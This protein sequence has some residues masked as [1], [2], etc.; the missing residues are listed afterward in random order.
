M[1]SF[2]ESQR[3]FWNKFGDKFFLWGLLKGKVYINK[4]CKIYNPK[5]NI[6]QETAAI[7]VD[8]LQHIV[9]NLEHCIQLCVGVGGDHF[10]HPI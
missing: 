1:G 7:P 9:A 6:H 5:E 2:K 8:M 10:Q 4:P 3:E